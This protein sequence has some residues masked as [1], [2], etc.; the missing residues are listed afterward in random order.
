VFLLEEA[1]YLNHFYLL[2]LISFLL[3]FLPAHRAFSVDA[4]LKP[5]LRSRVAPA[6]TLWLM[7]FQVGVVYFFGGIAKLNGDWLRGV[8]LDAWL[9]KRSHFRSSGPYLDQ[10]PVAL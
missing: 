7:R 8:P 5:K 1:R 4:Q 2:C 6:W 9:A 10:H 3:V